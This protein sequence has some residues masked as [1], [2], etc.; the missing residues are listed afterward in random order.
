MVQPQHTRRRRSFSRGFVLACLAS[1][2][3]LSVPASAGAIGR[4]VVID[5]AE[6]WYDAKVPY[7]QSKYYRVAGDPSPGYRQDCSGFVSMAWRLTRS[8]GTALS[9]DTGTLGTRCDRISKD[10][11]EPGDMLLRPKTSYPWGHAVLF[12]GWANVAHTQYWAYE[13]SNSQNGTVH[14]LV[15][16]PYWDIAGF[17]PYR[18]R[19]IE[20]LYDEWVESI[21][22]AT[23]YETAVRAAQ[24]AYATGS[25][26]TV[27]LAS[28]EN[29]PDALG[30]ASLAGAVGG[31]VL[32]VPRSS[33]PSEVGAEIAR[34]GAAKVVVLGG[35]GAVTDG[36]LAAV[37]A[38][39]SKPA[40]SRI[41]GAD[42]FET[43]ARVASATLAE[44]RARGR[45]YDG[46]AYVASGRDFPDALA[47]SPVA[48]AKGRPVLLVERECLPTA[49][50]EAF[51]PL[52][53]RAVHLLGG[54]AAVQPEVA[55]DVA[56]CVPDGTYRMA[57]PDRYE[58]AARVAEHGVA[59]GLS[60]NGAGLA[61]GEGFADALAG[62]VAQGEIGSVLLL[63]P[64]SALPAGA[65]R[66]LVEHAAEF[67][68]VRCYGGTSVVS[69]AVRAEVAGILD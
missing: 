47:V 4:D 1:L 3:L 29:W 37:R 36:V 48:A 58:T 2:V 41:G 62:G 23:R 16:Y 35:P 38:L 40:V 20:E 32:L 26:G 10:E 8:D 57:G 22:G 12:A 24:S 30:G 66:V 51:A 39:P 44:L 33:L 54:P 42:R 21:R 65:R 59:L 34:L 11:L 69:S 61:T 68:R 31:P 60:W 9:L 56:G 5:R 52:G 64:K 6:A 27:L 55:S 63:T 46:V 17:Q 28:G 45:A 18:Y 25:A 43:A 67:E 50:A 15:T 7:S 49:T 19:G 53:V 13:E 14:R